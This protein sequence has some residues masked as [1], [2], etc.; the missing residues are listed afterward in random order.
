MDTNEY[1]DGFCGF[2]TGT[3]SVFDV[4]GRVFENNQYVMDNNMDENR[5]IVKKLRSSNTF[6]L[7]N[8]CIL[9]LSQ[10]QYETLLQDIHKDYQITIEVKP[11]IKQYKN[12]EYRYHITQNNCVYWLQKQ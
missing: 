12:N 6:N 10:E 2:D 7:S 1:N 4:A 3:D 9:G 5:Y 8:R 11:Q